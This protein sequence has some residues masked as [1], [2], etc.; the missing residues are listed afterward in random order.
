MWA[1]KKLHHYA[2]FTLC[3]L[4]LCFYLF[5]IICVGLLLFRGMLSVRLISKRVQSFWTE[6]QCSHKQNISVVQS[7]L[8][9]PVR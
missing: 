3:F 4:K 1:N 5:F 8:A 7:L 6:Y 2:K 9:Q